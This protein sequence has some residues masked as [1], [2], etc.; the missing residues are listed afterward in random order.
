MEQTKIDTLDT[1]CNSIKTSKTISAENS[2]AHR[3]EVFEHYSVRND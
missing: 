2:F 3:F 1:A